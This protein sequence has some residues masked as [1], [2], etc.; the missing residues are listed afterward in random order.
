MTDDQKEKIKEYKKHT[1][2]QKS[3][4]FNLNS[5]KRTQ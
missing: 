2:R 1:M 5:Y 3:K 4:M